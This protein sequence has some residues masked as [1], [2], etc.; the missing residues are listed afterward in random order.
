METRENA[1]ADEESFVG[2][3]E[4]ASTGP[5]LRPKHKRLSMSVINLFIDITLLAILF[6]IGWLS[7]ILRFV[8]PAPTTAGG[9]KLWGLTYDQWSDL[10]FVGL[11]ASLWAC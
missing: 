8:F 2:A 5:T 9:W 3:S 1:A 6:A 4:V 11:C 10:Q 7:A